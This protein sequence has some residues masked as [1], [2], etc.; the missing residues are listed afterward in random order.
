MIC[1]PPWKPAIRPGGS[2]ET[3]ERMLSDLTPQTLLRRYLLTRPTPPAMRHYLE[4]PL[5][6]LR[7]YLSEVELLALDF[8]TTGLDPRSEAILSIGYVVIRDNRILLRESAHHQIQVNTPIPEQS[9]RIH[10]ITDQRAQRGEHLSQ[11]MPTLLDAMAGRVLLAHHAGIECGFI[12]AA[13]RRLYGY[14][15]PMRV[16]D[17]LALERCRAA[18]RHVTL[19]AGQLR[20]FNLRQQ[21][22]LP[23]YQAHN[24]LIDAI[25]TAELYLV[26]LAQIKGDDSDIR[27]RDLMAR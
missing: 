21:Y 24:A 7:Q 8:E 12:N 23:R 11:I 20:L 27:L 5:P 18:R 25:A 4:T 3:R 10:H 14:P 17:T 1:N 2:V 19:T 9:V 15:L 16:I 26:Q 22:G 13:C 6:R